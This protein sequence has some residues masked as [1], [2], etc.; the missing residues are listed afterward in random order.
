MKITYRTEKLDFELECTD[1]QDAFHQLHALGDVFQDLKCYWNGKVSD[2]T[3]FT[4]RT[5]DDGNEY[6]EL[7]Y[8]GNDP[9]FFGCKKLFGC[10]N[11]PKQGQL[12]PKTKDAEGNLLT[13]NIYKNR[14]WTR[15]NKE[16]GELE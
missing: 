2:E 1:M 13:P 4:V 6:F 15:W 16:K 11:K 8:S 10:H 3:K 7:K 5:D 12:F 9:H 14:G